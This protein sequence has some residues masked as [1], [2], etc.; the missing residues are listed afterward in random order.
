M[1]KKRERQNDFFK[2]I[3]IELRESILFEVAWNILMFIPRMLLRL[4]KNIR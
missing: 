4:I 1:K 3:L 2:E